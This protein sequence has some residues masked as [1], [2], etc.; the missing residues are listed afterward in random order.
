[1][2][3]R[4][5]L[6]VLIG[7]GL[8]A[9]FLVTKVLAQSP[10]LW[11]VPTN[12]SKSGAA[13]QS[14]I[15]VSP[16]GTLHAVW[17]DS[18]D[19]A[20][21]AHTTP[22]ITS[23]T[24]TAPVS[25]PEIF[26]RRQVDQQTN[27]VLQSPPRDL[28]LVA[29]SGGRVFAFWFDEENK[30]LAAPFQENVLGKSET[31]ATSAAAVE[32]NP[33]PNGNLHL[34]QV[35]T[36]SVAD[37]PAGIYY[38]N[39][40][41]ERWSDPRLVYSS[42]YFRTIKPENIRLS[43]ADAGNGRIIVAWDD[44][45][46]GQSLYTRSADNAATWSKPQVISTTQ[47]AQAR[48]VSV[49]ATPSSNF[50]MLWQEPGTG[51]CGYIQSLSADGGLTWSL[52]EKVLSGL[53]RCEEHLSFMPDATGRLWLVGQLANAV[54]TSRNYVSL[55]KWD[56]SHWSD[57]MDV[58]Q[59]FID[60]ASGRTITLNCLTIAI[61][62]QSAGLGGCDD[63]HDIW[64]ARN[65]VTL[66]KLLTVEQPVWSQPISL[67]NASLSIAEQN[68]PAL[69][70][71]A[72]GNFLALWTQDLPSGNG[73]KGLYGA[74]ENDG[75]WSRPAALMSASDA[76]ASGPS[77]AAE[78]AL[79]RDGQDR[80]HAVWSS[81]TNGEVQYSWTYARDFA[82]P[83]SWTSPVS[84]P[85]PDQLTSWPDIAA[86]SR[87]GSIYVLYAVPYNEKRGIYL[88][89]SLDSGT[90]WLTPT[91]IFDAAAAQWTSVDKPRLALDSASNIL[92]AVWLRTNPPGGVGPQAIYY[93]RS[94]DHGVTW[95]PAV[96][97]AEGDVD[98]PRL[99]IPDTQKV[100]LAWNEAADSSQSG[101]TTPFKVRGQFSLDGGQ[102][103]SAASDVRGFELVSGPV[104]LVASGSGHM[105][106]AAIGQGVGHEATLVNAE[107]NGQSWD[108]V[109]SL[110]LG[111][112]AAVSNLAVSAVSPKS[113]KLMVIAR[114]HTLDQ[115]QVDQVGLSSTE[116][117][118][119]ATALVP[120]PTFTPLPTAT[121]VATPT[122]IPQ[123]PPRPT[124]NVASSP[125]SSGSGGPS[126][127]LVGAAFAGVIVVGVTALAI[128]KKR[129]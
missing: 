27:G 118:V 34:L 91:V 84:L 71:D 1:M 10:S 128:W 17:W 95:S 100:Y 9:V 63:A 16:D 124:I 94:T 41:G 57:P 58:A 40:D 25:V 87:D 85:Q 106:L 35:N 114:L 19:G 77:Y 56:G 129:S 80:V 39:Y 36:S 93:S 115:S 21:Y 29:S 26:G 81:G 105:Y 102:R 44:P 117:S 116:R 109:Q 47:G 74:A 61:A 24:W 98:W 86:D 13:S 6:A 28:R 83:Q 30:L 23:T 119:T 76:S 66:D 122:S 67:S 32:V 12:V 20:L 59:F 68:I 88:V 43:V 14:A 54:A 37:N 113:G 46:L 92:H 33:D 70:D 96:Q 3:N 89:R 51:G 78:P 121:A 11:T 127:L 4:C 112:P 111:Q 82:L 107:W 64:V 125:T 2:D 38:R 120:L 101:P 79:A 53:T 7:L 97:L 104:G 69:I 60:P 45:Q 123:P 103:W 55:A 52:P 22:G 50:L 73:S 108:M 99:A 18:F 110:L 15:T 5:R 48:L 42:P 75:R 49:T 62:G 126:A 8:G 65:S 31:L 90:T 72:G